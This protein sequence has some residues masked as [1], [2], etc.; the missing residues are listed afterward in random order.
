M[1]FWYVCFFTPL[2]I[3]FKMLTNMLL[4]GGVAARV[5]R[6]SHSK[7]LYEFLVV[8]ITTQ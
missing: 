8:P 2:S 7:S 6:L 3:Y 5:E 1:M 4:T